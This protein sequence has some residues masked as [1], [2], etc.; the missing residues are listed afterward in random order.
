MIRWKLG[1]H[2]RATTALALAL[3]LM[4]AEAAPARSPG[5]SPD[6]R[7]R[8]EWGKGPTARILAHRADLGLTDD[9]VRRLQAAESRSRESL[10]KRRADLRAER[11]AFFEGLDAGRIDRAEADRRIDALSRDLA[12][13]HRARLQALLEA[14]EILTPGQRTKLR[15]MRRRWREDRIGATGPSALAR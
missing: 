8:R 3:V 13:L 11:R 10:E 4:L 15:D 6:G 1:A 12:A 7:G 5:S 9:Q 14:R 2:P